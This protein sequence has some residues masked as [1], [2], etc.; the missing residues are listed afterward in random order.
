M[1][2][3][4]QGSAAGAGDQPPKAGLWEVKLGHQPPWAV[5]TVTPSEAS[6]QSRGSWWPELAGTWLHL[7]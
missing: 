3:T 1:G 7:I 6:T 5:V 2:V 4:S